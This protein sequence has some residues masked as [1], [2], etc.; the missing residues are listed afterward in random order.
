MA[1]YVFCVKRAAE[2]KVKVKRQKAKSKAM[3]RSAAFVNH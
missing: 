3:K 2:K 1:C